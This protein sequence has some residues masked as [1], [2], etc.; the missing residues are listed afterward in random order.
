ML[1]LVIALPRTGKSQFM[2]KNLLDEK[3]KGK[4]VFVTN[5]KQTP[6]QRHESGFEVFGD[7]PDWDCLKEQTWRGDVSGW[8]EQ[9][10][11]G[12]VWMIDEAQDVFPQRDKSSIL[13]PW[14][15]LL[16]K[17]GHRDLTIY[18]VTQDAMQLDV[19]V[20]RNSNIT[21]YM[22]RPLN[23]RSAL[24]YTFRGYQEI[25]NDAWRRLQVLKSAESKKKFR[26]SK[27]YQRLY[28]SASAHDHIKLRIPWKLFIPVVLLVVVVALLWWA[29]GRL[30]AQS[31]GTD[32]TAS[33][34][35]AVIGA[36]A[37][38]AA[39]P[40]EKGG[41]VRV[42]SADDYKSR[43]TPRIAG[44]PWSAP[45]YDGFEVTDYP[46]PYCY[47]TENDL[48]EEVCKCITQQGSK[49][50]ME[51]VQCLDYVQNGYFDPFQKKAEPVQSA[52]VAEAV[53][54]ASPSAVGVGDA[55]FRGQQARYGQMRTDSI[56]VDYS[57]SLIH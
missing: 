14:I 12:A 31:T 17:H 35:A 2:V 41:D 55:S 16:S 37:P 3:S 19:H 54:D 56:P 46:R 33:V 29:W 9:L 42:V 39:T 36:Q 25:P 50:A 27:K 23:M 15:K 30:K 24:I 4:R 7:A 51:R 32:A 8:L 20:R 5:F 52:G 57:G 13:P 40:S 26:Y 18:V 38:T 11:E 10:P 49:L 53:A 28:V 21:Y 34:A 22:T 45:A 44:V 48:G 47:V 1:H 43:F 6:E